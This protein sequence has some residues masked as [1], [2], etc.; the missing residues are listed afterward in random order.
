MQYVLVTVTD[1]TK[2][3]IKYN[4]FEDKFNKYKNV[5]TLFKNCEIAT[6]VYNDNE[7]EDFMDVVE[8]LKVSEAKFCESLEINNMMYNINTYGGM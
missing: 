6:T 5:E 4:A 2:D 7:Y 8:V 3:I 1:E